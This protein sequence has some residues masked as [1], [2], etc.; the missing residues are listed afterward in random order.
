VFLCLVLLVFSHLGL[1]LPKG[2][3]KGQKVTIQ[4]DNAQES[5]PKYLSTNYFQNSL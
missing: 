3:Q 4:A 5:I 1:S 2:R